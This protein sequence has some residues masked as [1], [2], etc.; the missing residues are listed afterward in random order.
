[1][2]KICTGLNEYYFSEQNPS[3]TNIPNDLYDKIY[4]HDSEGKFIKF[5]IDPNILSQLNIDQIWEI[6]TDI[7]RYFD[8][9]ADFS[10]DN[11][12]NDTKEIINCK[13]CLN[14][15]DTYLVVKV[16]ARLETYCE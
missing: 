11:K 5:N 16:G 13:L 14:I 4:E 10:Y 2:Y 12:S 6:R 7:D 1:M 8:M 3:E 9:C 15:I